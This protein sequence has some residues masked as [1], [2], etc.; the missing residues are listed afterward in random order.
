MGC[1]IS[2]LYFCSTTKILDA[3]E[4]IKKDLCYLP[5]LHQLWATHPNVNPPAITTAVGPHGRSTLYIQPLDNSNINPALRDPPVNF[6]HSFST[7]TTNTLLQAP[8]PALFTQSNTLPSTP[9]SHSSSQP[10]MGNENETPSV[11]HPKSYLD[12][13]LAKAHTSIKKIPPKWSYEDCIIEL[14]EY[15]SIIIIVEI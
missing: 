13:A 6:S 8:L 9:T 15:I 7:N 3:I 12:E 4:Q 10:R 2:F 5:E 1:V 11:S 14:Q